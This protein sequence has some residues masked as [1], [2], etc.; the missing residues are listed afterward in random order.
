MQYATLWE[1]GADVGGEVL[2]ILCVSGEKGDGEVA[3]R[4][5]C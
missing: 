4:G 5:V 1:R 2:Q 3:V